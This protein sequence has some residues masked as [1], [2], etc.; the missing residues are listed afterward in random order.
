[1]RYAA[2]MAAIPVLGRDAVIVRTLR[3][4]QGADTTFGWVWKPGGVTM[5][6]TG[7]TAKCQVRDRI[8][9]TIWIEADATIDAAGGIGL[10]FTA[11]MTTGDEWAP[12][13]RKR[14]VWDL[15]LTDMGG[16]VTRFAMGSVFISPDVTRD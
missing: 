13:T 8:N 15:E 5:D 9:G 3:V 7:W 16:T 4:P 12:G 1:M 10:H 11:D 6:S 14:G 2:A